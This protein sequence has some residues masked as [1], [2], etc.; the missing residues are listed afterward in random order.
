MVSSNTR[1]E[2]ARSVTH[3]SLRSPVNFTRRGISPLP[4]PC[5]RRRS[6]PSH[7]TRWPARVS[8]ARVRDQPSVR[9]NNESISHPAMP[10]TIPATVVQIN[11]K[12]VTY[13]AFGNLGSGG[14]VVVVRDEH[15]R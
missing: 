3:A 6:Y 11:P 13:E 9:G 8:V 14:K 4:C 5:P 2:D 12:N 10:S 1:A 7:Q 15:V